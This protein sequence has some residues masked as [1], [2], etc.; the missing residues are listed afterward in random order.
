MRIKPV[1][2][3]SAACVALCLLTLFAL[4]PARAFAATQQD[5]SPDRKRA[6]E[7]WEKQTRCTRSPTWR[8]KA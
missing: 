1:C 5:D 8:G 6:L 4:A 3:S 2:R 7:M